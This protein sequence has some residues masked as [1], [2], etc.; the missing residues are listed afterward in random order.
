VKAVVDMA[1]A[2]GMTVVAEGIETI[3]HQKML[4]DLGC[5]VGQ[6]YYYSRPVSASEIANLLKMAA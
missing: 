3:E 6:G 4:L 1:A 5:T 2:F